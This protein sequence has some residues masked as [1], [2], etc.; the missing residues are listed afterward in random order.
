MIIT[1]IKNKYEIVFESFY[2][3]VYPEEI[4]DSTITDIITVYKN[5]TFN[6]FVK[7]ISKSNL[8]SSRIGIDDNGDVFI[9]DAS[10]L[11]SDMM[12]VLHKH[13]IATFIFNKGSKTLT[14]NDM[15]TKKQIEKMINSDSEFIKAI[16]FLKKLDINELNYRSGMIKI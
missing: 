15:Y 5:P 1:K 2:K 8:K 14:S 12:S 9:W 4:D 3:D 7:I 11:H 6:E 10:V 13:W 16:N